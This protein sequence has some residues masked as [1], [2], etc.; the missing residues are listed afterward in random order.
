MVV[1]AA[2]FSVVKI[3][4]C[5]VV[6]TAAGEQQ[7]FKNGGCHT[8]QNAIGMPQPIP[9]PVKFQVPE[10]A[11]AEF[12]ARVLDESVGLVEV[13]PLDLDAGRALV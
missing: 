8:A 13:A 4:G 5:T 9:P 2:S 11:E 12:T 3:R 7:G 6:R 1:G 10:E